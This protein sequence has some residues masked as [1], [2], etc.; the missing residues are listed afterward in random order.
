MRGR[1]RACLRKCVCVCVCA[2]VCK[3]ACVL[4]CVCARMCALVHDPSI[5]ERMAWYGQSVCLLQGVVQIGPVLEKSGH[6][7]IVTCSE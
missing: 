6:Y 3:H 5:G 1:V 4:T 7:P 2:R